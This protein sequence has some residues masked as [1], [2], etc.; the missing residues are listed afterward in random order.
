MKL[1]R[2]SSNSQEDENNVQNILET[3]NQI[4]DD[5]D[6]IEAFNTTFSKYS[7][8]VTSK[9]EIGA[10]LMMSEKLRDWYL[11]YMKSR[12][13]SSLKP[14]WLE[15]SNLDEWINLQGKLEVHQKQL[16]EWDRATTNA[17]SDLQ[18]KI[19]TIK[20]D[21]RRYYKKSEPLIIIHSL[22][23]EN[24]PTQQILELAMISDLQLRKE[25]EERLVS[26][27]K[28]HSYN[29]LKNNRFENPYL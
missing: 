23:V 27:L 14:D 13:N 20:N 25:K 29:E 16:K 7:A 17:I 24:L 21:K 12:A 5:H 22:T 26:E 9:E 6:L 19:A 4:G 1:L 28:S 2:S 15:S 10:A 18:R 3:L 8:N 11:K